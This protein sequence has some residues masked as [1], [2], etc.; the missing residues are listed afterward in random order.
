MSKDRLRA[1]MEANRLNWDD[2]TAVHLR[3][4]TGFTRLTV[5]RPAMTP[6][7][8]ALMPKSAR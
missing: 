4:Q 6:C 5:S 2:R 8:A 1:W 3:N 7:A